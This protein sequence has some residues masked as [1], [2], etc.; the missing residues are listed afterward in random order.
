MA[1]PTRGEKA[2]ARPVTVPHTASAARQR[3]EPKVSLIKIEPVENRS[4]PPM[5]CS[6]RPPMRT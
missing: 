2:T 1:P 4:A 6:T 3:P 5:P